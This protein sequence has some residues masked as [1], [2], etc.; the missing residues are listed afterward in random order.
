MNYSALRGREQESRKYWNS[1]N[2]FVWLISETGHIMFFPQ[3]DDSVMLRGHLCL[4][5]SA[6]N[7]QSRPVKD[8]HPR[9]YW[10]CQTSSL[11]HVQRVFINLFFTDASTI[12]YTNCIHHSI[13]AWKKCNN[14]DSTY[15]PLVVCWDVKCMYSTS[16][17]SSCSSPYQ[18]ITSPATPAA[19]TS[20]SPWC[21]HSTE[22]YRTPTTRWYTEDKHMYT[23]SRV[24][25][26]L[27]QG[28]LSYDV[29]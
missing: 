3:N 1:K 19:F 8:H 20:K 14:K 29:T 2:R 9:I 10:A 5:S 7:T 6:G 23:E 24:W 15:S 13:S 26:F 28:N 25:L 21:Q 11:C 16:L 22:S 4:L 18:K 17:F 12:T 27:A